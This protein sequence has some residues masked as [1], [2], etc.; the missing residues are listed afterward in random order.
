MG[1]NRLSVIIT[2]ILL[3]LSL[4]YLF[5]VLIRVKHL[6]TIPFDSK[7]F[8]KK[9][10]QSQWAIPN[11]KKPIS[12]EE[13]YAY[14]GYRYITGLNPVLNSPEV[15]PL[16]KYLIGFSI[17]LFSNQRVVTLLFAILSLFLLFYLVYS[18]SS[19]LLAGSLAVFL[20]STHA[21]FVDQILH[22]PQIDVF[23]LFF[24]LLFAFSI[25]KYFKTRRL[26][27]L[28]LTGISLGAFASIKFF[29][30]YYALGNA[31]FVM[32]YLLKKEKLKK[33][34]LEI[35]IINF[36]AIVTYTFTYLQYF[37]LGGNLR[38]F[39]GVQKWIVLFYRES[40]I[41]VT[42]LFGN[43]LSLIFFNRWRFWTEG[44]PITHYQYWNLFW[45]I[46]FIVGLFS[47]CMIV[48][49]KLIRKDPLVLFLSSFILIY[50]VFLFFTPIFPRY[51]L[52]LYVS[53]NIFTAV[54]FARIFERKLK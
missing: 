14:A 23:Q 31:V 19:S 8:E 45:P 36:F 39:L 26:I 50:N 25:V 51:L 28:S 35:V 54:Y 49:E 42:K 11:S 1:K 20:T 6:Y 17:L 5:F 3:F 18:F 44:L 47:L 34:L 7:L 53:L 46:L 33:A 52:L 12:D 9:Y 40:T 32:F 43:Y 21:L 48:K 2:S 15:P 24:F 29:L 30:L 22:S 10:Y 38:G 4:F 27:Y 41:P 13:L 37:L 16:G